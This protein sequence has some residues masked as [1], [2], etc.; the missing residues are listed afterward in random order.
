MRSTSE[1]AH[2]TIPL[3]RFTRFDSLIH[4]LESQSVTFSD[5]ANWADRNDIH[6]LSEYRSRMKL[7]TLRAMCFTQASETFHHWRVFAE[8]PDGV[9]IVFHRQKLLAALERNARILHGPVVYRQLGHLPKEPP[10]VVELPFQKRWPYRDELEYRAIFQLPAK[11]RSARC[12]L[13]GGECILEV[14][15]SPWLSASM[16]ERRR[17]R[18]RRISGWKKFRIYPTT[19]LENETWKKWCSG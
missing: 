4:L 14:K 13:P 12:A 8:G 18:I 17:D 5:P 1:T 15:F 2:S 7:E 10:T 11:V 16:V 3:F 19:I 6:V 9:C